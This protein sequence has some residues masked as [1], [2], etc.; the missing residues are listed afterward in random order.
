M[1]NKRARS[2]KHTVTNDAAVRDCAI[3]EGRDGSS[4]TTPIVNVTSGGGE[5]GFF[6]LQEYG[7]R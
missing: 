7:A 4:S 2:L 1:A 6:V 3:A 5:T